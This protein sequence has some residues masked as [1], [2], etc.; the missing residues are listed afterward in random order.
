[1]FAP[2]ILGDR[3]LDFQFIADLQV[4]DVFAHLTLRIILDDE[5]NM[6]LSLLKKR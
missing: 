4:V 6:A 5:V 3:T 1:L 2:V